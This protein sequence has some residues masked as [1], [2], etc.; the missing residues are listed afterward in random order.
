M[1][2]VPGE[3]AAIGFRDMTAEVRRMRQVCT[4]TLVHYEQTV[5]EQTAE[6]A[7]PL[8]TCTHSR[9]TAC[10]STEGPAEYAQCI[11]GVALNSRMRV[12]KCFDG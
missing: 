2:K 7:P 3:V 11:R 9:D 5:R 8:L 4:G 12:G 1:V 6:R 10:T